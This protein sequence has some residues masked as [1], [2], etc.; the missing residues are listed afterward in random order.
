MPLFEEALKPVDWVAAL[1]MSEVFTQQ[2]EVLGGRLKREQVEQALRALAERNGVQMKTAL[3][4]RM[5]V[6]SIRID[7]LLASLQRILNLDG[8][9]VLTVDASQT[10]RL[11]LTLLREQFELAESG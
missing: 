10:V 7:G 4:Q 11:N 8:Y 9:P 2:M 3:A 1:L 6:Q 5:G